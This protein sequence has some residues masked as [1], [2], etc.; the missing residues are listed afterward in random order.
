ML[1]LQLFNNLQTNNQQQKHD[2]K[3]KKTS[4]TT[5]FNR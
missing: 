5:F 3:S 1:N 4:R 2:R